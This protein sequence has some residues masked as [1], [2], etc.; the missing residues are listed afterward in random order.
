MRSR[1]SRNRAISS[2]VSWPLWRDTQRAAACLATT[3]THLRASLS[4]SREA[5]NLPP[6]S[7]ASQKQTRPERTLGATGPLTSCP[8]AARPARTSWASASTR[9]STSAVVAASSRARVDSGPSRAPDVVAPA[10]AP[11]RTLAHRLLVVEKGEWRGN[12]QPAAT[13]RTQ[14]GEQLFTHREQPHAREPQQPPGVACG[15]EVDVAVHRIR[16]Q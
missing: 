13:C 6:W 9:C 16:L 7:Q 4:A 5:S 2:S 3:A 10:V 8:S 15:E 14:L 11:C 12:A 1:S